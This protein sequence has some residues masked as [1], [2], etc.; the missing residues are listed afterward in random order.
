M[1]RL[2]VALFG[3]VIGFS[4]L[5]DEHPIPE[6]AAFVWIADVGAGLCTVTGAPGSDGGYSYMV[7]DAGNQIWDEQTGKFLSP[8]RS[9]C[10]DFIDSVAGSELELMIISHSDADHL[11]NANKV[12]KDRHV[13]LIVR[14]GA[15]RGA[16][17]R[18]WDDAV[19]KAVKE[20]RAREH[21]LTRRKKLPP[22]QELGN[23]RVTFVAGWDKPLPEWGSWGREKK[24]NMISI[25][26]RFE[27]GGSSV[28]FTGDTVGAPG[29]EECGY[30]EGY[31][32]EN[33]DKIPIKSDVL[34]AP[35]H[36]SYDS[37]SGCF[38]DA[39]CPTSVIFP[40]GTTN[41]RG[42]FHPR[43]S[44]VQRYLDRGV[45]RWNVFRT[46]LCDGDEGGKEWPHDRSQ[47]Q[48]GDS[49]KDH[50]LVVLP[51]EGDPKVSYQRTPFAA[52]VH[53]SQ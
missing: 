5:A 15:E 22:A 12:L 51:P 27:Y 6:G 24:N 11:I 4:A 45:K 10:A 32:V 38:I 46:D 36:G 31:I 14:T 43:R 52:P 13:G 53:G 42:Y 50:V 48:S 39:V 20:D 8:E 47:C 37:S 34:I 7:Y 26:A 19:D 29:G 2:F 23:G 49:A 40:S 9:D 18:R 44:A 41:N 28:L 35:H 21:N 33:K 17:W 16:T 1:Y 3:V 25:V 30:A